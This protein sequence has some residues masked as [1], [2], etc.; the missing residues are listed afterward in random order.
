MVGVLLLA[1]HFYIRLEFHELWKDEWQSWFV[2]RDMNW[3]DM[4]RFLYYEGHPALWYVYLKFYSVLSEV[5]SDVL[6]IKLSHGVLFVAF[7][8]VVLSIPKVSLALKSFFLLG[9]YPVFEYGMISRGYVL[10]LIGV[11]LLIHWIERWK[12]RYVLFALVLFLLCQTEIY[13]LLMA[14][15]MFGYLLLNIL[16][17]PE[18]SFFSEVKDYKFLTTAAALFLGGILFY[19]TIDWAPDAGEVRT[20]LINIMSQF[21]GKSG[22]EHAFQGIFGH[23]FLPGLLPGEAR[24][25]ASGG[26]LW[27]SLFSL[28]LIIFLLK[29][30]WKL[31]LTFFFFSIVTLYFASST[32]SGGMRQWGM[33]YIFFVVVV[34][35]LHQRTEMSTLSKYLVL[36]IFFVH[37]VFGMRAIYDEVRY[38]FTNAKAA[39]AFISSEVPLHIPVVGI[40]PFNVAAA[41]GYAGRKF[42]ELPEGE[43]FSYFRWLDKVYLPQ[44]G[45]LKLFAA[46]KKSP[47]LAIVT[48]QKLDPKKYPNLDLVKSF[49]RFS[50]KDENFYLYALKVEG[51]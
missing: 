10:V 9:Y 28:G 16:T 3:G 11:F 40:S 50:L 22:F 14:G 2:A 18:K 39:G 6:L 4:F 24:R 12:D 25:G 42:Y 45:E 29:S 5:A 21:K 23:A 48:H 27:L 7:T 44:E 43:V 19:W 49:D 8:V 51:L 34:F 1:G 33:V 15:F 32:Y 37:M 38:P 20:R 46:F 41:S 30:N 13:G 35:L 36:G 17:D 31:M 47:G 26:G